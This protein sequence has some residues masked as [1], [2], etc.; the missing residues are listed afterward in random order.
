[1]TAL[2]VARAF[3]VRRAEQMDRAQ[4]HYDSRM[5][6]GFYDDDEPRCAECKTPTDPDELAELDGCSTCLPCMTALLGDH[7][8]DSWR[9]L[10]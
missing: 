7:E 6:A 2:E 1:M 9:D 5:P 3:D 8:C 10:V 4:A